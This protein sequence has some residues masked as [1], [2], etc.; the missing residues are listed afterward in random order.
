[1]ALLAVFLMVSLLVCIPQACATDLGGLDQNDVAQIRQAVANLVSDDTEA[2]Q[3]AIAVLNEYGETAVPILVDLMRTHQG[4]DSLIGFELISYAERLGAAGLPLIREGLVDKN[5]VTRNKAAQTVLSLGPE[6]ASIVQ[7]VA[8][9]AGD[10]REDITIRSTAVDALRSIGIVNSEVI[11][12]LAQAL[13]AGDAMLA[14]R[15]TQAATALRINYDDI[16]SALFDDLGSRGNSYHIIQAIARNLQKASDPIGLLKA[17]LSQPSEGLQKNL[18]LLITTLYPRMAGHRQSLSQLL[19]EVAKTASGPIQEQAIYCLGELAKDDPSITAQLLELAGDYSA[20][21]ETYLML[22]YALEKSAADNAE[23][24]EFFIEIL[25]DPESA[26]DLRMTAARYLEK[27]RASAHPQV[28]ALLDNLD[29]LDEEILWRLS[30]MF[31]NAA[32]EMPEVIERLRSLVGENRSEKVRSYSNALLNALGDDAGRPPEIVKSVGDFDKVPAFPGAEGYGKYTVGG[33]G[34]EVYVVTN[35]NDRGPGSLREAVEATG[36]RTVVFAV[37]GNIML[38]EALNINNPYITIAGQTAP[39]DGITVAGAP[40]YIN[41]D[42]VI[43]RYMRFRMGDYNRIEGDT[44]GGRGVSNV[45]LDHISASWSVDECLSFYECNNVT[46][47]WSFIT[48]SLRGSVHVKGNHG[49]GGIWGGASSFHHNLLAHHSSRNPRFAPGSSDGPATDMRNNVIYNW[50]FNSAYGGEGANVNMVAN[51][52]KAGPAT[53]EGRLKY[54]I[55]E[56]SHDGKWYVEDNFVYGYPDISADN[57]AGGVQ[58]RSGKVPDM[59]SETEFP[60]P[61]VATHS[62]LEAYE[63]VLAHAGAT[64]P[65]RDEIDKRI[66]EEVRTGT[67]TYGGAVTGPGTG[68]IDSQEDVG[69]LPFL[70]SF[71][72]PLDS[73]SDGIPDWWAIKHGCSPEGGIDHSGDIDGDGYTNLEEYLNG[74][75]PLRSDYHS[76][77]ELESVVAEY[78]EQLLSPDEE[79]RIAAESYLIELGETA[80]PFLERVL[81]DQNDNPEVLRGVVARLLGRI[82][83]PA[84]IPALLHSL[85]TDEDSFVRIGAL[86]SLGKIGPK[87]QEVIDAVRQALFDSNDDVKIEAANVLGSFGEAAANEAAIDLLLLSGSSNTRFAWECRMAAMAISPGII[88]LKDDTISIL[89]DRL[90]TL[91]WR[92]LAITVLARNSYSSLPRIRDIVL[93]PH[94]KVSLRVAALKVLQKIGNLDEKT[95]DR[96][97]MVALDQ[98]EPLLVR[99]AAIDVLKS[100]ST[101]K[102]PTL[103]DKVSE[104]VSMNPLNSY[105]NADRIAIQVENFAAFDRQNVLVQ[106]LIGFPERYCIRPGASLAVQTDNGTSVYSEM[107]PLAFWDNDKTKVRTAIV[108]FFPDLEAHERMVCWVDL[109]S[110]G[111]SLNKPSSIDTAG[112]VRVSVAETGMEIIS[113][114]RLSTSGRWMQQLFVS[115]DGSGEFSTVQEAINAVPDGNRER[116]M[117][118]IGE[119][120]YHEKILI[121]KDKAMISLIGE[122]RETTILDFNETAHIQHSPDYLYNTWGAASTIVL[123]NDFTAENLTFSNSAL[124]GTG[125]A[126]AVRLEGDRMAFA[127]C[128]FTSH[129]DTVYANGDGRQYFYKCHIEGDVDFIYGSAT[130]VFEDC[131]IV[132]VRK[133]GG[134]IT[135]ASTPEDREFGFVF[136]NCRIV[137]DVNPGTV[138]LGRPWRP[139][140]HVA[141]INCYMSEVVQPAGW[142]NWGKVSNEATA[143]YFEYGNYGPGA[144]VNDR[145]AW[146]RQLTDEEAARYTVENILRG[147]DGW[148]PKPVS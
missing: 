62:A 64:L 110:S 32:K 5:A 145:V 14:W 118:F 1:M 97:I 106:A 77:E 27:V 51:Y 30:P 85:A 131:D 132:N 84:A 135:A 40:V 107:K 123:S 61:P 136:I 72:A 92:D 121:P 28:L 87:E 133:T 31:Y 108:T 109:S 71:S 98:K 90:L 144:G 15:A 52:F 102:Y 103:K 4:E 20:S 49:Y 122:N 16:L 127:N 17:R 105:V 119:G 25:L 48:E 47:Q 78:I 94:E 34:G 96:L 60:V 75:N 95:E 73:D 70:R 101:E 37:S 12:G 55:V 140:A 80:I 91:K 113:Q 86:Q 74:T 23:V 53:G 142:H 58:P 46:V 82:G 3:A 116:I 24:I 139:Y 57:W 65:V 41:T 42:N 59:R 38:T 146:S 100:V 147:N 9:V 11:Q 8:R 125:Q 128:K 112:Q 56:A 126:Q 69:G 120:L 138:W 148:N 124:V 129:Q 43:I 63:L 6:A 45:I 99:T 141:Y 143:R 50:G 26:K 33:R 88:P 39:G 13:A 79:V 7:D 54:K 137:G 134:Y 104:A 81:R 93:N 19:F 35:L 18:Y 83:S 44:I 76:S 66:V 2:K 36:P 111:V 67:A 68:I 115:S 117:I 21:D 22:A 114:V 10:T 89:I 130:A 29:L